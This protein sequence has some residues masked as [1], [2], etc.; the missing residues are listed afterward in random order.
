MASGYTETIPDDF[1]IEPN[2][3]A[4]FVFYISPEY[5]Q[6]PKDDLDSLT[7]EIN[8]KGRVEDPSVLETRTTAP[9]TTTT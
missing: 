5:V 1:L 7:Y 2:S 8:T 3:T 6:L 9:S 4:Y